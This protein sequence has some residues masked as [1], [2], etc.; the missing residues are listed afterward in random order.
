MNRRIVQIGFYRFLGLIFILSIFVKTTLN[1]QEIL[2]FQYSFFVPLKMKMNHKF[3]KTLKIC[4]N[5]QKAM[6][7]LYPSV[8]VG[9][10]STHSKQIQHRWIKLMIAISNLLPD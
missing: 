7:F 4:S 10:K 2:V 3:E 1:F 5:I 9:K 6:N 8:L